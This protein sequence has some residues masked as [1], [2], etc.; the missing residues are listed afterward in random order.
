[1]TEQMVP[2]GGTAVAEPPL[3]VVPTDVE[4]SGDG[5]SRRK[6]LV[7]GLAV[8]VLVVAIAGYFLTKG[9]SSSKSSGFLVPHA[10]VPAASG[11]KHHATASKPIKLPQ[12]YKGHVGQDPFKALYTAPVAAPSKA[13]TTGIS[14]GTS[15]GTGNPTGTTTGTTPTVRPFRPVWVEL[16]RTN[17]TRS[18]TFVVGYGNGKSFITKTFQNVV[19][20]KAGSTSGTTFANR[21]ALLSIQNGEATVQF[22]D[23]T[24]VDIAPGAAN[25][26]V[27]R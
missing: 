2:M 3:P 13:P 18:A 9:G 17:G 10:K 20:P 22:G 8:A 6:L 25:R 27:V 7:V 15:T 1:M 19:V 12:A 11:T 4:E 24:P 14:T 23:G 21:F 5:S 16:I 26:L